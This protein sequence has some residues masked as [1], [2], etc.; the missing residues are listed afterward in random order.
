MVYELA[1]VAST[2]HGGSVRSFGAEARPR[3]ERFMRRGENASRRITM[4]CCV[5]RRRGAGMG[6]PMKR[7]RMVVGEMAPLEAELHCQ[8]ASVAGTWQELRGF[9]KVEHLRALS[10]W[11]AARRHC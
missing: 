2:A 4:T 10:V 5:W 8:G 11:C 1:A 6:S 3:R 9:A 7:A